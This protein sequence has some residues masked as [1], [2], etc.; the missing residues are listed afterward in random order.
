[1]INGYYKLYG[2]RD[3]AGTSFERFPYSQRKLPDRKMYWKMILD[4]FVKAIPDSM[5]RNKFEPFLT[6]NHF[7]HK[8]S[9]SFK[10]KLH[11]VINS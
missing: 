5:P 8:A 11:I 9:G 10:C 7:I 1:M 4:T 3:K 6:M 2:Q